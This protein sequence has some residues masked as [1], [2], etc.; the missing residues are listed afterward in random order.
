MSVSGEH[1]LRACWE[2]SH[3]NPMR[4]R[5]ASFALYSTQSQ[6]GFEELAQDL[7]AGRWFLEEPGDLSPETEFSAT[8]LD[9]HTHL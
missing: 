6:E 5:A 2:F 3:F 9:T 7:T 8:E 1:V 4:F